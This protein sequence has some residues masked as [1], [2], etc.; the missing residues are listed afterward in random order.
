MS[1]APRVSSPPVDPVAIF[2]AMWEAGTSLFGSYVW[3][4]DHAETPEQ[5]EQWWAKA[6]AVKDRRETVS[7]TDEDGQRRMMAEFIAEERELRPLV[8]P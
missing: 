2:D 4:S 3:L 6:L 1:T 7:A 5:A 8:R